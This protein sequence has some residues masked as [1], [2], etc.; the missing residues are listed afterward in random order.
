MIKHKGS[1]LIEVMLSTMAGSLI[2]VLA[3]KLVHQTFQLSSQTTART[4]HSHSLN[5]LARQF[6][7]DIHHASNIQVE[8]D[9]AM[10][11]ESSNGTR[12]IY[13]FADGRVEREHTDNF[14]VVSHEQ[15]PL[16]ADTN[17]RFSKQSNPERGLMLVEHQSG[18]AGSV[19]RLNLNVSAVAGRWDER[20]DIEEGATKKP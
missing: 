20:N 9:V 8:S 12:T 4:N 1:T 18:F 10:S 16:I 11:A 3:I 19:A 5:R 13:K 14:N 2:M 17:V 15:Y 7:D 6:R